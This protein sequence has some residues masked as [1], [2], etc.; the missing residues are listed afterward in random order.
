MD[1]RKGRVYVSGRH[2]VCTVEGCGRKHQARGMCG[3]H[4]QRWR[5]HGDVTTNFAPK[6]RGTV[7]KGGYRMLSGI[8]HPNARDH[9][10]R[11]GFIFEHRLVMAGH[12]GRPLYEDET[13][14]HKNGN[15]LDNRIKNLE[16]WSGNHAKG[17]RAEDLV[18]WA[19]EILDRYPELV[20]Q[21]SREV[22]K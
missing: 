14:H 20:R 2:P 22:D 13:V 15:K 1:H 18:V 12:L 4:Y 10:S 19:L 9:G 6:G 16:V 7:T 3:L 11:K 5:H 8:D 21:S 17:S